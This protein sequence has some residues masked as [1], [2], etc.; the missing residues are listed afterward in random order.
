[1]RLERTAASDPVDDESPDGIGHFLVASY[2]PEE[3]MRHFE[4]HLLADRRDDVRKMR[5]DPQRFIPALEG[6]PPAA[7]PHQAAEK[8]IAVS[9]HDEEGQK[10][11]RRA[12]GTANLHPLARLENAVVE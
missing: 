12:P 11:F 10:V 1:M 9:L 5:G 3:G 7:R 4:R 6:K 2:R 8:A